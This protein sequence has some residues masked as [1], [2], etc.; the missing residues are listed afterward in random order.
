LARLSADRG[1]ECASALIASYPRGMSAWLAQVLAS[2]V[3]VWDEDGRLLM[4]KT[5]NRSTLILPGG[6]VEPGE[7]PAVAGHREV[8][9]EVGLNVSVGRLLAVQHLE[10]EGE[11]PSSVQ[12]VFDSKPVVG[13]PVLTLQQ[14]EIADALWLDPAEAVARHGAGGQARL[15]AA[16]SAHLGGPVAFLDSA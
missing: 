13:L 2:G 3:L 4:V 16:L 8:L 10:A 1:I 5:H 7:S 15:R 14:D 6:L 11:K 12:F 9:E